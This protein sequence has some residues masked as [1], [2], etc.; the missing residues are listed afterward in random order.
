MAS[1]SVGYPRPLIY[2]QEEDAMGAMRVLVPHEMLQPHG[3]HSP[4]TSEL[5]QEHGHWWDPKTGPGAGRAEEGQLVQH[6]E[7]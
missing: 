5:C 4:M 1:P 6:R 7:A 3:K 2:R